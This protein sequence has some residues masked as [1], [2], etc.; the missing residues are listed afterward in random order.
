M[1]DITNIVA[2]SETVEVE[3]VE[4][5][6]TTAYGISKVVNEVLEAVGSDKTFAPQMFYN[7]AKNGKINGVKGTKRFSDDEVENFVARF[8]ARN[9]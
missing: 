7:Y 3:D 1:I 5:E 2:L 9:K 8:V 6:G 4:T